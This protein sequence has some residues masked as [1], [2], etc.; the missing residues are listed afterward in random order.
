MPV[1]VLRRDDAFHI[2]NLLCSVFALDVSPGTNNVYIREEDAVAG[3]T[4]VT[5]ASTFTS[6]LTVHNPGIASVDCNHVVHEAPASVTAGLV[7]QVQQ[8]S[9]AKNG[10]VI[11][12]IAASGKTK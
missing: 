7:P 4:S 11:Y 2:R 10:Y 8:F 5:A 9:S 12:A 6:T 1:G 3:L